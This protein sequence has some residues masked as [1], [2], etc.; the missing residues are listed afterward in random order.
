MLLQVVITI[1]VEIISRLRSIGPSTYRFSSYFSSV[2][3]HSNLWVVDSGASS[4]F[5]VVREYFIT[6]SPSDSGIVSG[7]STRVRGH[8]ICKLTLV[9]PSG[10]KCTITLNGVL[11]VPD[12]ALR[13]N[14]N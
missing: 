6:L 12:F 11:Y 4:H 14:G 2:A 5:S 3:M 10:R 8:R 7:I 9:D 13:S 1:S